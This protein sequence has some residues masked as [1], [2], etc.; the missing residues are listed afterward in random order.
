MKIL[1]GF[2]GVCVALSLCLPELAAATSPMLVPPPNAA[3]HMRGRKSAQVTVIVYSDLECP[4]CRKHDETLK[5]LIRR[6]HGKVNFVFRHFP[7]SFHP[8]ARLAAIASECVTR[9]L[10]QGAFWSFIDEVFAQGADQYTSIAA[11]VGLSSEKLR[12]C[13]DGPIAAATVDL[14]ISFAGSEVTGTPASFIYS[15]KKG[16]TSVMG[17]VDYQTFY[18]AVSPFLKP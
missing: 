7:L 1:H 4:F 2:I 3:D 12:S 17:A 14:D 6:T 8:S 11:N 15:K 9:D 18:D 10:G 5:T 13:M 16:E